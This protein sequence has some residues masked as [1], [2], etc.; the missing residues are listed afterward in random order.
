MNNG[1]HLFHVICHIFVKLFTKSLN[2][3]FTNYKKLCIIKI[4]VTKRHEKGFLMARWSS[5]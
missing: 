1:I 3:P 2:L 4:V 5:G